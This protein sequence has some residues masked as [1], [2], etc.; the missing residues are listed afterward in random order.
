MN[1]LKKILLSVL[2]LS[3]LACVTLSFASCDLSALT[4]GEQT[5]EEEDDKKNEGEKEH[6][7]EDCECREDDQTPP[8]PEHCPD[9]CECRVDAPVDTTP[10]NV[11]YMVVLRDDQGNIVPGVTVRVTNGTVT[12]TKVTDENGFLT[13]PITQGT[14]V[15]HVE[16]APLGY[17]FDKAT[18]HEFNAEGVCAIEL[19]KPV[20]YTFVAKSAYDD[21]VFAD[22]LVTLHAWDAETNEYNYDEAAATG[23]TDAE[24]K[25]TVEVAA[26]KY[27]AE[28]MIEGQKY[29]EYVEIDV[30]TD[31]FD[32]LVFDLEGSSINNPYAV[33]YNEFDVWDIANG[34]EVWYTIMRANDKKIVINDADAYVV[35]NGE[36]IYA[37]EEGIIEVALIEDDSYNICFAIG[38]SSDADDA[39]EFK[40]VSV[41]LVAPLGSY[42][43][44]IVLDDIRDLDT[45]TLEANEEGNTVY[46]KWEPS[47]SGKF[48]LLCDN[49]NNNVAINNGVVYNE[50]IE[51]ASVIPFSFKAYD[52]VVIAVSATSTTEVDG[53]AGYFYDEVSFVAAELTFDAVVYANYTAEIIDTNFNP[54]A[55]E[56]VTVLDEAGEQVAVVVTDLNGKAEVVLPVG[57]Y[58]F[59]APVPAGYAPGEVTLYA[60]EYEAYINYNPYAFFELPQ[61]RGYY[62]INL[63]AGETKYFTLTVRNDAKLTI[64]GAFNATAQFGPRTIFPDRMGNIVIDLFA[65]ADPMNMMGTVAIFSVTNNGEEAAELGAKLELLVP[66]LMDNPIEVVE[67]ENVA[68]YDAAVYTQG[69]VFFNYVATADGVL[70]LTTASNLASLTVNNLTKSAYGDK[71]DADENTNAEN[72][73]V[74]EV[75]VSAGD[76][77]QIVVGT[78][79]WGITAAEI[80]FDATFEAAE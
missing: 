37:D 38:Y 17:R 45:L 74:Y 41:S 7:P 26:G 49:A 42:E 12:L 73:L 22:V 70:T 71:V 11:T 62:L 57:T 64:E 60:G 30:A 63:A 80:I 3:L 76:E 19:N 50:A 48:Y 36:Y 27:V 39:E 18:K 31:V 1:T 28:F 20:G 24:G 53:G 8:A 77:L 59:T 6:C 52:Q 75:T 43:N 32:V 56:T 54:V 40:T 13:F 69:A 67:G 15:A 44:P 34:S 58:T 46:Y 21:T 14:W 55:G 10:A 68:S 35:Y 23:L 16:D 61:M 79:D 65:E 4:G 29:I 25:V 9:D 33:E 5:G 66:G 78:N 47:Y 72:P 2:V 51:G